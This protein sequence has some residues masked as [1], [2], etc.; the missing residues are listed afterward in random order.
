MSRADGRPCERSEQHM[1]VCAVRVHVCSG[2]QASIN[3]MNDGADN[4]ERYC[5]RKIGDW[6]GSATRI[7]A[8][9]NIH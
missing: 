2:V 7:M 3:A 8:I 6:G 9:N 1:V 4:N 5:H